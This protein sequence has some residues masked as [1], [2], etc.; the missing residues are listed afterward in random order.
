MLQNP[1]LDIL[2]AGCIVNKNKVERHEKS[3]AEPPLEGNLGREI[4]T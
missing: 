3:F 1:P 4:W 2:L